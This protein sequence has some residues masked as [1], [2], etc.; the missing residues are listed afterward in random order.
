MSRNNKLQGLIRVKTWPEK[1]RQFDLIMSDHSININLYNSSTVCDSFKPDYIS[2]NIVDL[3]T[4]TVT[5]S[6]KSLKVKPDPNTIPQINKLLERLPS[7]SHHLLKTF[8]NKL[9]NL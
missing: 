9:L 8:L 5:Q 4:E 2:V 3:T 7:G 1:Y 6:L